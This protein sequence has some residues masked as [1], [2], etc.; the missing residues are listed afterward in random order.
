MNKE[1]KN[2]KFI[3]LYFSLLLS[4]NSCISFRGCNDD[5]IGKYYVVKKG[6]FIN[7]LILKEDGNY[8]HYYKENGIELSSSG[9]WKK[10]DDPYC[11]ISVSNWENYNEKG[12]E[13]ETFGSIFYINGNYL[14]RT[15]DGE[16]WESFKKETD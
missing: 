9:K 11:K 16:N 15:P 14:D 6:E 12:L 4:L 10:I 8:Y 1:F 2:F 5:I 3:L 13:Y 7:Y